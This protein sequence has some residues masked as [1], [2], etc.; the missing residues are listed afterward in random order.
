MQRPHLPGNV[1][2]EEGEEKDPTE[3]QQRHRLPDDTGAK[4]TRVW[5]TPLIISPNSFL[6]ASCY[7]QGSMGGMFLRFIFSNATHFFSTPAKPCSSVRPSFLLASS[8]KLLETCFHPFLCPTMVSTREIQRTAV[9]EVLNILG[10]SITWDQGSC[11]GRR[12][13][14]RKQWK[15]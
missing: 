12:C 6:H 2:Q 4:T 10:S 14:E 8:N 9:N 5:H 11:R 7:S 1:S 13:K 3:Q 15:S